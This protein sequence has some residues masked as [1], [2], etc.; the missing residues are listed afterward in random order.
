MRAARLCHLGRR[1]FWEPFLGSRASHGDRDGSLGAT[2]PA[3]VG[4]GTILSSHVC[5]AAMGGLLIFEIDTRKRLDSFKRQLVSSANAQTV[6][7]SNTVVQLSILRKLC[8]W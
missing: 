2:Q 5:K 1:A 6:V 7:R 4:W 3:R 8:A